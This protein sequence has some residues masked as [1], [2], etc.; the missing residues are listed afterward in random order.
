MIRKTDECVLRSNARG[1]VGTIEM[2]TLLTPEECAGKVTLCS[3]VVLPGH[4]SIGYHTHT[5]DVEYYCILK[6]NGIFTGTDGE[7]LR[8]VEG[9]VCL[10]QKGGSHGLEND[11]DEPLEMLALVIE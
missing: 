7:P 2:H 8:V 9:D 11:G 4:T 1:G 3:R 5:D 6:G 10:I